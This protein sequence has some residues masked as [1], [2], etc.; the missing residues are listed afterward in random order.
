MEKQVQPQMGTNGHECSAPSKP[1]SRTPRTLSA[2]SSSIMAKKHKS[3]K[4]ALIAV[5]K[6][7]RTLPLNELKALVSETTVGEGQSDYTLL[8]NQLMGKKR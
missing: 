4:D 6:T 2:A 3:R 5:L 7:L 8:A 1:S